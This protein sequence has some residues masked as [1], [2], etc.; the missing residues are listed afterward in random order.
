LPRSPAPSRTLTS[1]IAAGEQRSRVALAPLLV[2]VAETRVAAHVGHGLDGQ[3]LGLRV[4][5]SALRAFA[6]CRF[7]RT[8]SYRYRAWS[9]TTRRISKSL[10][11]ARSARWM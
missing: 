8:T 10:A 7:A 4:V 1:D 6:R 9:S 3:L 5:P 11:T 2:V